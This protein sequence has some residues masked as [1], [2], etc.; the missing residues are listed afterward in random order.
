LN[1][2]VR[3]KYE[4]VNKMGFYARPVKEIMAKEK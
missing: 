1:S 2:I 3:E 4:L